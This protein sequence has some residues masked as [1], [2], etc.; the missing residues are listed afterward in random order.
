M[1]P[2]IRVFP[3][4]PEAKFPYVVSEPTDVRADVVMPFVGVAAMVQIGP[5]K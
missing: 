3:D 4:D 5:Q 1:S 2:S